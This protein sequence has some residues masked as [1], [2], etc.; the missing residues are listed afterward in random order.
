MKE[1]CLQSYL[2]E[3]YIFIAMVV[4]TFF[5]TS[6]K[7]AVDRFLKRQLVINMSLLLIL[8]IIEFYSAYHKNKILIGENF[9]LLK[10]IYYSLK[11]LIMAIV[12]SVMKPKNRL[13]YIPAILNF[14]FYCTLTLNNRLFSFDILNSFGSELW[15]YG[16]IIT[17]WVYWSIFLLVLDLKFY[18]NTKVN[19]L[20]A[21]CYTVVD[22]CKYYGCHKCKVRDN[23]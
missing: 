19:P 9:I 18:G 22:E 8:S 10:L 13:I 12:V 5:V 16:Y 15:K 20:S 11:P 1:T 23:E 14:L 3:N 6:M 21:F 2:V 17:N 7:S 4:G